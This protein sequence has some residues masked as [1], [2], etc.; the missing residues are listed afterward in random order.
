MPSSKAASA[1]SG[2]RSL[3]VAAHEQDTPADHARV[4]RFFEVVCEFFSVIELAHIHQ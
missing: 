2:Q 3:G 1:A 4:A